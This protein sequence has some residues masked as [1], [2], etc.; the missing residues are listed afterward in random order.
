M[1]NPNPLGL[2]LSKRD[3]RR[4]RLRFLLDRCKAERL[5]HGYRGGHPAEAI[6]A[7]A[8]RFWQI[9]LARLEATA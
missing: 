9:E 5:L 2:K 3:E 4:A 1:S 8:E 7:T 6:R